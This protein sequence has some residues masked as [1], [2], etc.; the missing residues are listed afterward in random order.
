MSPTYAGADLSAKKGYAVKIDG[1]GNAI[2]VSALTDVPFGILENAPT[3]GKLATITR[4]GPTKAVL[5]TGGATKGQLLGPAAD[6]RLIARALGT[7]TTK[8]VCA[9]C[10]QTGSAGELVDVEVIPVPFRAS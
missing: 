4:T 2:V 6:G 5:G 9:V 7:D 10:D 1:S 8:Y 3:S